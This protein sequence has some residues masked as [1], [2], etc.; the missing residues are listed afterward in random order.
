[1]TFLQPVGL[2]GLVGVPILILIY[3]LKRRYR[4]ETVPSTFLWRRSLAYMKHR[5][6]WSLRNSVL[7]ALQLL[8]VIVFSLMLA[9]PRD[10]DPCGR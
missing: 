9:R 3:I 10:C 4:E 6:P 8:G 5:L 7:L 1:M 2:V